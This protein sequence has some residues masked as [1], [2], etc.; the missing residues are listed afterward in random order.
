MPGRESV[1]NMF[2]IVAIIAIITII[3]LLWSNVAP[4]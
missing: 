1:I 3:N 4:T 2:V